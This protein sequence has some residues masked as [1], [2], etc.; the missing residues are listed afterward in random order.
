MGP[1]PTWCASNFKMK[2]RH[3][4]KYGG[5]KNIKV[6]KFLCP[7]LPSKSRGTLKS[8]S[9]NVQDNHSNIEGNVEKVFYMKKY[10]NNENNWWTKVRHV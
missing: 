7:E 5:L 6:M 10:K 8:R 9:D 3:K 2:V 4:I 1:P